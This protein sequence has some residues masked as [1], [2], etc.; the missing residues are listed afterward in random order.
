MVFFADV[1][2]P[3]LNEEEQDFCGKSM[4]FLLVNSDN[5]KEHVLTSC[6]CRYGEEVV[7]PQT[8]LHV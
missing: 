2:Q 3:P 8:V 5:K 6:L 7:G 4:A 1:L